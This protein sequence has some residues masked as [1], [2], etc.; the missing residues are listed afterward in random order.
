MYN[1]PGSCKIRLISPELQLIGMDY[2]V[3]CR[4]AGEISRPETGKIIF[5]TE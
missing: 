5:K 4:I 1:L 2:L 3:R